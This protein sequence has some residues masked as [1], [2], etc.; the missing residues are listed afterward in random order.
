MKCLTALYAIAAL[1]VITS[2]QN[3]GKGKVIHVKAIHVI[4]MHVIAIHV[5]MIHVIQYLFYFS[6]LRLVAFS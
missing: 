5:V 3:A 1:V 2:A 6:H 4:A